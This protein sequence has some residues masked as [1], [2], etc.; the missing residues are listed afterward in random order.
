MDRM[1]QST[2]QLMAAMS[3][4]QH[5]LE[6]GDALDA[7]YA[8][9]VASATQ[10]GHTPASAAVWIAKRSS[11]TIKAAMDQVLA[12]GTTLQTETQAIAKKRKCSTP[13][14]SGAA[15]AAANTADDRG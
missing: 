5:T 7:L 11:E 3:R 14:A 2:D 8:E 1:V 13:P 6:S 9:Y 10:A 15:A 12:A 4:V